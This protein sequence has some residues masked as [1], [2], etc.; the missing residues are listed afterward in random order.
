[1]EEASPEDAF[2]LMWS[3]RKRTHEA[4]ELMAQITAKH[5]VEHLQRSGYVVMRRPPGPGATTPRVNR[6]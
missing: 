4:D 2:A 3:G 5:L 6:S 1:M